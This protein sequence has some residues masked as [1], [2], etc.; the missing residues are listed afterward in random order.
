[1]NANVPNTFEEAIKCNEYKK[2]QKA[3]DSEI[4]SLEK[5]DTWLI[6]DKP[7]D[8]KI[9]DVKWIYKRKSDNKYKTRLVVRGF[10]QKNIL[11]MFIHQ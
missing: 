10:Q 8:K 7:K 6:V 9:I 5:N 4:K 3:M 1:M 11:K 2:W